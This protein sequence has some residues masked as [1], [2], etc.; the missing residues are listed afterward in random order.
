MIDL[1]YSPSDLVSF[2]SSPYDSLIKKY[3]KEVDNLN[4]KE[5]P[6]DPNVMKWAANLVKKHG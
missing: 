4:A 2:Y 5:D 1:K 6:E 3:I